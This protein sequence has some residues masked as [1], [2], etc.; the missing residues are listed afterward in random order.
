MA[1]HEQD[2]LGIEVHYRP[3]NPLD[4][5]DPPIPDLAPGTR[6]I[7]AGSVHA[8]GARPLPVDIEV[9]ED[10]SIPLRDG[11]TLYG[12]V[13]RPV[14][15][16]PVPAVLIY[17][18][19]AKRGGYWNANMT[20]TNFG[21]PAD[22]V[23][24]LQ[25]F[26]A[27]DPAYWC[28]HDYAVVVVDARGTSHSQGD[29]AFMGSTAGRDVY[30]T[31]EWIASQEWATGKVAMAGNSQ[32]AMVQWAGAALRPPHLAA[33]APWEGLTDSYRDVV[34]RGGIP[35]TAFHDGDI[36]DF[37]YGTGRFEDVTEMLRHHPTYD[38]YWADKRA[39]LSAVDIPAYVVASWSN[40]IHARTTLTAFQQLA[41]DDK[42]LRLHN[43]QEWVDIATPENVEDLRRFFDRYLKG[44]DNGWESTP[45]V[46]YAV[47]DPGGKD[48]PHRIAD[49]WPPVPVTPTRLYLD[50]A[51]GRLTR[52]EPT[53]ESSVS[54]A[55]TD[56]TASA[57]FRY[58]VEE[59]TELLGPLNIRLWI[60]TSEGS[61]LDLFAAVYKTDATG[62]PLHHF[63]FPALKELARSLGQDGKFPSALAYSGP[64]GRIRASHRALDE[65]RSTTLEPYLSHEHED[66]VEP[67]VPVQLDLGLW[68]TGMLIHAGEILVL[69][70]AGHFA[71]PL[72]PPRTGQAGPDTSELPTRNAGNHTIRTGGRFGSCA[73]L[74]I[75]P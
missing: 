73:F 18:P 16:E 75:A 66:L 67:G 13:Y 30:D 31:V 22:A 56:P 51:S 47:L 19:Y 62:K 57:V 64:L 25:P 55:S 38:A 53:A 28:E 71:G 37:L 70:I 12:D 35:D 7:P 10:V 17:T 3:A 36:I 1:V 63:P 21:V 14:G 41:S 44:Q 42:W 49:T 29:M 60:E 54:Y 24:G 45:R 61:D 11:V 34:G 52:D 8:E 32:L 50:A 72:T 2:N 74:P 58:A 15:A 59:E 46:R 23:S 27:L 48:D 9:L 5:S 26:E 39:D 69:E 43:T 65:Q 6:I 4:R 20:A 33:I 40:P 68:P